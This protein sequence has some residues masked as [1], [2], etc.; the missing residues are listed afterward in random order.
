MGTVSAR[1]AAAILGVNERTVRRWITAGRVPARKVAINRYAIDLD[2]LPDDTLI[3]LLRRIEA[4]EAHNAIYR[5]STAVF[6][7]E[8]APIVKGDISRLSTAA[9]FPGHPSASFLTVEG[10]KRFLVEHGINYHT[11]RDYYRA[12]CPLDAPGALLWVYRHIERAGY[13][14]GAVA[15]HPC[16]NKECSCVTLLAK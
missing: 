4:L 6:R 1:Q 16:Q 13:R 3:S 12:G 9:A 15:L 14:A 11:S 2:A 10:L 7:Q 5:A 8:A